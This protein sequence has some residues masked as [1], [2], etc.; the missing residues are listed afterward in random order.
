MVA[1]LGAG[2]AALGRAP[3][4][5]PHRH[6]AGLRRDARAPSSSC[7]PPTAGGSTGRSAWP[8]ASGS[9][10]RSTSSSR[11][12]PTTT[13]WC[14]PSGPST[15]SRCPR[16]RRCCTSRTAV[17]VLTQAVLPHPMLAARWRWNLNRAL[18]VP[19][20]RG[21]QR[22]PIHLQRMEA[23]D[24]LAAA[25]PSLAACQENAAP[26]SGPG[27]RPRPGAPDGGRLPDR[28]ARRRRP[29]GAARGARDRAGSD[30]HFVESAEPSPL[31][32]GILTGRPF[33]FLDGAPLE[34]RRTR[35]VAVPRG[36]GPLDADRPAP[37]LPV[38]A[39]RA[40]AARPRRRGRGARSDPSP[41][42][43]TADELHDL[44]LSL[45]L[46][47]P[48]PGWQRVVRRAGGRRPGRGWWRAAGRPPS[49][50]AAAEAV[51]G[52][53]V[54]PMAE[55]D[56]ALAECVGGHLDLAGP[57]TVDA[58]VAEGPLP[59]GSVRGAPVTAAR[60]RTALARLEAAGS[61][62]ELP[63][64][65]WCARHLLVRHARGQPDRRRR[66]SSSRPASPTSSG[67]SPAGSTWPPGPR[68]RAGRA[69]WR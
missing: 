58:L 28:A 41:A 8:C 32:H 64:G 67:S 25:W 46:C 10:S 38:A 56:E 40:G 34:E 30:V 12:R 15:A 24:L 31:A 4:P 7:T 51:D 11:R 18:V 17:D 3:H 21:G 52:S 37:G 47:R 13:P 62:I 14:C 42:P 5:G 43:R 26:G 49:A 2:L 60:A 44:L 35:A 9:A 20:S 39:V 57:V 61:A 65:R 6:R 19:R 33:T 55:A 1:Y 27:P 54:D 29:G 66:A 63:D 23:E 68:P 36:L 45:V 59:S 53:L 48:V 69:C 16:C 22:R 50:R